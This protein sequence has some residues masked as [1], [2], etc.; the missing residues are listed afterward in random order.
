MSTTMLKT[1]PERVLAATTTATLSLDDIRFA[2]FP[3]GSGKDLT[4]PLY[5]TLVDYPEQPVDRTQ[6]DLGIHVGSGVDK[7]EIRLALQPE[8]GVSFRQEGLD[9]QKVKVRELTV[10]DLTDPENSSPLG[11]YAS[12]DKLDDR[13]SCTF[14]WEREQTGGLPQ[15]RAFRIFCQQSSVQDTVEPPDWEKVYG[16]LFVAIID[17]PRLGA[18]V[19]LNS[20][21]PRL[22]SL[23]PRRVCGPASLV[24]LKLVGVDFQGRPLYNIFKEYEQFLDPGDADLEIEPTYRLYESQL[25]TQELDVTFGLSD[26]GAFNGR[27]NLLAPMST[28]SHFGCTFEGGNKCC[29]LVWRRTETGDQASQA[30]VATCDLGLSLASLPG[31]SPSVD[32]T[33]IEPPRCMDGICVG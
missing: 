24:D 4:R 5:P 10:P 6:V 12:F 8:G 21:V 18:S 33:V 7:L 9:P 1:E 26:L 19:D 29:R 28:R 3:M 25:A 17:K 27:L 15:V 11:V 23:V 14:H 31:R 30:G 13:T 2:N 22:N 16:G 32:P 20:P